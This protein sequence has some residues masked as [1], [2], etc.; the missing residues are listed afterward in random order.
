MSIGSP[1]GDGLGPV[2]GGQEPQGA[3]RL[4]QNL[5]ELAG[6]GIR[7]YSFPL[8]NPTLGQGEGGPGP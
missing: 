6:T 7:F 3:A 8:E 2:D 1:L 5:S 4:T